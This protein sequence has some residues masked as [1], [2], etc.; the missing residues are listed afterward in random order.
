MRKCYQICGACESRQ[1][2]ESVRRDGEDDVHGH[3]E[4]EVP[5][6]RLVCTT[7]DGREETATIERLRF[8]K[9]SK[10]KDDLEGS[11]AQGRS[12]SSSRQGSAQCATG[13]GVRSESP[14]HHQGPRS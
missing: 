12:S 8:G 13:T 9:G 6:A 11:G 14:P 7:A 3:E 5:D 1:R 10:T 2:R 4:A